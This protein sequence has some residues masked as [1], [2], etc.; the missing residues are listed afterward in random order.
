MR[1]PFARH[2]EKRSDEA[3]HDFSWIATTRAVGL[4]MT[5][6]GYVNLRCIASPRMQARR[7]T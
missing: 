5:G 4:A 1:I 6:F 7:E 3:I 2:C